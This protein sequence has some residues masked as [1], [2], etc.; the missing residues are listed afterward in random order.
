M[1]NT[2]LMEVSKS[3]VKRLGRVLVIPGRYRNVVWDR[4]RRGVA[5]WRGAGRRG[6]EVWRGAG[7]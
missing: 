1:T 2:L 7:R 3:G 6:L 5:V 4:A